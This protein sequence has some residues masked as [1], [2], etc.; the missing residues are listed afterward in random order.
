G[1]AANRAVVLGAAIGRAH[2]QRFAQPVTERLQLVERR[3]VDEQLAGAPACDLGGGEVGP[4]PGALRHVAPVAVEGR[5][6]EG[7][8]KRKTRLE[9]GCGWAGEW[10]G[11]WLRAAAEDLELDGDAR[12]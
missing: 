8:P 2:D 11:A 3:F 4:A 5:G 10:N 9:G 6:H 1:R 12:Q 7:P